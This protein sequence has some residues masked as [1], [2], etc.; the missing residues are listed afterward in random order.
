MKEW[1]QIVFSWLDFSDIKT[2]SYFNCVASRPDDIKYPRGAS[3]Q[4]K[5]DG[6][7]VLYLCQ[8]VN[9]SA[10]KITTSS[11]TVYLSR[12]TVNATFPGLCVFRCLLLSDSAVVYLD[13]AVENL[14]GS[15]HCLRGNGWSH[16]TLMGALFTR[17]HSLSLKEL[18][19]LSYLCFSS[20]CPPGHPAISFTLTKQVCSFLMMVSLSFCSELTSVCVCEKELLC[21]LFSFPPWPSYPYSVASFSCYAQTAFNFFLLLDWNPPGLGADITNFYVVSLSQWHFQRV[22][23][24]DAFNL[25]VG[26]FDWEKRSVWC[27]QP[28]IPQS[29]HGRAFFFLWGE[30][31]APSESPGSEEPWVRN[32]I[33]AGLKLFTK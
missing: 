3:F 11:N 2:G 31:S 13:S 22:Y 12:W 5:N 24:E 21:F 29:N 30:C 4:S 15:V 26:V 28:S 7:S 23:S 14:K 27:Y 19:V 9:F 25:D 32:A 6:P 17:E 8:P 20:C 16:G 18:A 10:S 1:I 33:C